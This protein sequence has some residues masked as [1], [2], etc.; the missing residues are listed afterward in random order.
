M[1]AVVAVEAEVAVV[2]VVAVEVVVV[3]V[4]VSEW[5]NMKNN[6]DQLKVPRW[7]QNVSKI[8]RQK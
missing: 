2:A 7:K 6:C 8:N 4:V 5:V 1:V 3:V